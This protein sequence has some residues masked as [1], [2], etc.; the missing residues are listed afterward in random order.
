M[1]LFILT[2]VVTWS[3]V[4][5]ASASPSTAPGSSYRTLHTRVYR[6]TNMG[7]QTRILKLYT[8]LVELQISDV[9]DLSSQANK[10]E[11]NS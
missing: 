8:Y 6:W 2:P 5:S 11:F 3:R 10:L 9:W 4:S 7:I 1:Q